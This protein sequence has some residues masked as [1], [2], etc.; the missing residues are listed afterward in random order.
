[1]FT[2]NLC[3]HASLYHI[4]EMQSRDVD[5]LWRAVVSLYVDVVFLKI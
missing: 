2:G 3:S 4:S 5:F 1:M